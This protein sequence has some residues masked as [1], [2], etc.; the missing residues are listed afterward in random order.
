MRTDEAAA[1]LAEAGRTAQVASVARSGRPILGTL[2][3]VFE[4][5]RFWFYSRP[6]GPLPRAAARGEL[7]AVIVDQFEPPAIRQI[8]A[9]GRGEVRAEHDRARI[10]RIYARYFGDD[11][12][13]WHHFFRESVDDLAYSLW[14]VEPANGV[15]VIYDD[16]DRARE[17]R[18]S[19]PSESPLP[20]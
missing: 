2:L 20:P 10:R 15:A 3:F 13:H 18:W 16:Y 9:T 12:E 19:E 6:E 8:R 17:V 4:E 7:V 11:V 1:F 5:G 14:A